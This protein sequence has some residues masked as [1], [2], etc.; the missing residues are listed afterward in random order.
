[1]KNSIFVTA[2][3]TMFKLGADMA[4]IWG[5]NVRHSEGVMFISNLSESQL[6]RLNTAE[7]R[8]QLLR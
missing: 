3:D 5:S 2:N 6:E 7:W 1:M 8:V 4:K